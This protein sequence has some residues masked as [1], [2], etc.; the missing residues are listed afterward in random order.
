MHGTQHSTRDHVRRKEQ[1]EK[2]IRNRKEKTFKE[3]LGPAPDTLTREQGSSLP[4][5]PGAGR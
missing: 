4:Y 3:P 5:K 1:Q 2:Q